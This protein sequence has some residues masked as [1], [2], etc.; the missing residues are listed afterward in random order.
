MTAGIEGIEVV[1]GRSNVLS[2]GHVMSGICY[3]P[4]S[5][6]IHVT[7]IVFVPRTL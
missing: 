2:P 3:E 7:G 1:Q 4:D 5:P 6:N